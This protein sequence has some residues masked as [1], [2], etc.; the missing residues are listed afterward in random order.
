MHPSE[1]LPRT[2]ETIKQQQ[3]LTASRD[4]SLCSTGKERHCRHPLHTL[5]ML[6]R[7]IGK[8]SGAHRGT[9]EA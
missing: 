4:E 5:S 6:C 9:V 7:C 3:L 2:G 8:A 1:S